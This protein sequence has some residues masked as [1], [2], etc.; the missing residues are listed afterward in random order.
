MKTPTII[1]IFLLLERREEKSLQDML[2][3]QKRH[4]G[5]YHLQTPHPPLCDSNRA[6]GSNKNSNIS[7]VLYVYVRRKI[8]NNKKEQV[9]HTSTRY[10]KYMTHVKTMF[11]TLANGWP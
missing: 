4:T 11:P 2:Q 5:V 10:D 1:I 6:V 7:F 8:T 3:T 9:L